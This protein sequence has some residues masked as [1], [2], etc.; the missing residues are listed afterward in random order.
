MRGPSK[1]LRLGVITAAVLG[2]VAIPA[3]AFAASPTETL[4]ALAG[5]TAAGMHAR[6][7]GAENSPHPSH[8]R[9]QGGPHGQPAEE[10]LAQLVASLNISVD[11]LKAAIEATRVEL[12]DQKPGAPADRNA[13]EDK[14]LTTLAGKLN[15]SVDALKTAMEQNRPQRPERKDGDDRRDRNERRSGHF[16]AF[17]MALGVTPDALKT[18]MEAAG[19]ETR[20]ATKPADEAARQAQQQAYIAALAAKLNLTVEKVTAALEQT[21]PTPPPQ[22]EQRA[23]PT[24]AEQKAMLQPRLAAMVQSGKLT[25]AQADQILAD[26]DAGKPVFEVLKQYMPQLGAPNRDQNRDHVPGK[27]GVHKQHRAGA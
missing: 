4:R 14:Y 26:I 6:L 7:T 2:A 21:K 12:K 27:P 24:A 10:H 25:Q 23:K 9:G 18:A 15:V 19:A 3:T 16:E 13:F 11:T 8:D 5:T 20:P 17:A 22:R 1:A